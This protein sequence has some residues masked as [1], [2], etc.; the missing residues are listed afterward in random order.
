MIAALYVD[1]RG[2]YASLLN[3]EVWDEKRD[4]RLYDGPWPVIAHPPC[5]RWCGTAALNYSRYG[6]EYNRPGN[7]GGCFAA[8]LAA[9]RKWGGVLEHPA[10]SRAWAAFGLKR[11]L[12]SGGWVRVIDGY[13]GFVCH[14]EQGMYGHRARKATWLY[15]RGE[16][17]PDLRWGKS[18]AKAWCSP[19]ASAKV[20]RGKSMPTM[21]KRERN[22]TPIEFRD[23]LISIA[24]CA[25]VRRSA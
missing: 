16:L 1:A 22:A 17:L 2:C 24:E 9:V 6:G 20:S 18:V 12:A 23:V 14:V 21:N 13:G 25:S 19:G 11:P 7:D 5:Q 15:A 8:A 4:A 3:V 10:Y